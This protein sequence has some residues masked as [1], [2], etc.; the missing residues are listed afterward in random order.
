MRY[1][2]GKACRRILDINQEEVA[3]PKVSHKD[4]PEP[5]EEEEKEEEEGGTNAGS[6]KEGA[7]QARTEVNI[8]VNG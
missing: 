8:K 1:L 4:D 6:N 5:E 7:N 2:L 3:H